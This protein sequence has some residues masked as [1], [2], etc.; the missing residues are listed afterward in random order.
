MD[1]FTFHSAGTIVALVM[2]N[3]D[4]YQVSNGYGDVAR[5][6]P[7]GEGGQ[8]W[9]RVISKSHANKTLALVNGAHVEAVEYDR[10][11]FFQTRQEGRRS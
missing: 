9:F 8:V 1:T 10:H 7:V 2:P 11:A 5:I 6:E 4:R 3:G